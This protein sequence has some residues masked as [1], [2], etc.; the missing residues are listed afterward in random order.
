[1]KT[2]TSRQQCAAAPLPVRGG[3]RGEV[4]ISSRTRHLLMKQRIKTNN[5]NLTNLNGFHEFK[6]ISRIETN[7][8]NENKFYESHEF[9]PHRRSPLAAT[10]RVINNNSSNSS[11]SS[12]FVVRKKRVGEGN[13]YNNKVA[14]MPFL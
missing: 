6:R 8:T 7:D 4:R 13:K 2:P 5:T 3:V 9:A 10:I 11:D 12:S 1:M 14:K